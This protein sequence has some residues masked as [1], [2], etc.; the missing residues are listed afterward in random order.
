MDRLLRS[1]S[2]LPFCIVLICCQKTKNILPATDGRTSSYSSSAGKEVLTGRG[3]GFACYDKYLK[4]L[5]AT[6]PPNIK[7]IHEY[8]NCTYENRGNTLGT[9]GNRPLPQAYPPQGLDYKSLT[10]VFVYS[11]MYAGDY[12]DAE[13]VER[14]RVFLSAYIEIINQAIL[15][16]GDNAIPYGGT[17]LKIN[18]QNVMTAINANSSLNQDD[19]IYV[20]NIIGA[21]Y[22]VKLVQPE[23]LWNKLGLNK[24][25]IFENGRLVIPGNEPGN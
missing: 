5:F 25:I 24:L 15:S 10:D 12:N 16:I 17:N 3:N 20:K 18:I 23:G 21:I 4:D 22:Y 13:K 19:T 11:D 1:L 7:A 6:T 8:I 9:P 2:A 14:L